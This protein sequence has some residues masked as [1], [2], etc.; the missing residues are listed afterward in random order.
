MEIDFEVT[1]LFHVLELSHPPIP[2]TKQDVVAEFVS[3]HEPSFS[4]TE[5]SFEA[6]QDSYRKSLE[7]C[8][9]DASKGQK[10]PEPEELFGPVDQFVA[11][12]ARTQRFV[13][14]NYR[15][16]PKLTLLHV[17]SEA[18]TRNTFPER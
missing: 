6:M 7:M 3:N 1:A 10:L 2:S 18:L 16:S 9:F 15:L 13:F 8:C 4:E 14:P 11:M 17:V 5:K 12:V